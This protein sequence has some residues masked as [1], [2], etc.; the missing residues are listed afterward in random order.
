MLFDAVDLVF[1]DMGIVGDEGKLTGFDADALG[2]QITEHGVLDYVKR[3]TEWN[4]G[5]TRGDEDV[6]AAVDKIPLGI[7]DATR[8]GGGL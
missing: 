4:V 5:R 2:N 3:K 1:V 8:Q 6:E 7:P